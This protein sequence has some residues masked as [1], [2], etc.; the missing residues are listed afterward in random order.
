MALLALQAMQGPV[1]KAPG[2]ALRHWLE[3]NA[4][5]VEPKPAMRPALKPGRRRARLSQSGHIALAIAVVTLA[6]MGLVV[7]RKEAQTRSQNLAY[8]HL[9]PIRMQPA[10]PPAISGLPVLTGALTSATLLQRQR[11]NQQS[12]ELLRLN[13][14]HCRSMQ[15]ISVN[16]QALV[17]VA[18][19]SAMVSATMLA[20]LSVH[21]LKSEIHW[22]FTVLMA[23]AFTLG[24]AVVSIETFNLNDNLNASRVLYEQTKALTRTF[25]TSIANQE[26]VSPNQRL[27]LLDR[28]QLRLYISL[29]DQQ[30]NRVDRPTFGMNDDFASR[31]ALV[32]LHKASPAV[33]TPKVVERD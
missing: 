29:I 11:L 20:L 5:M 32:L 6:G 15:W 14:Y 8:C 30:L 26:Y 19:G 27:N 22:P 16:Y 23:S 18:N 28:Q 10:M 24:L 9:D 33:S 12:N 3:M 7:G 1:V 31:E 21:G 13:R 25:A 2:Q 4:A 17:L